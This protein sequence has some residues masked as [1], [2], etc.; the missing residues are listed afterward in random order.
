MPTTDGLKKEKKPKEEDGFKK[1]RYWMCQVCGFI[2]P[3]PVPVKCP[4]CGAG[5]ENFK[6]V[7]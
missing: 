5:K 3:E 1:V 6:E 7:E 4:V 2:T